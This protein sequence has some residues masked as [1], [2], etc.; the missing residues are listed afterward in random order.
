VLVARELW[1]ARAIV[2]VRIALVPVGWDRN[3]R[4]IIAVLRAVRIL[5]R[6]AGPRDPRLRERVILPRVH[7]SERRANR[8]WGMRVT[9]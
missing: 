9:H 3:L 6:L 8:V 5:V 4:P 1:V 7:C 2:P